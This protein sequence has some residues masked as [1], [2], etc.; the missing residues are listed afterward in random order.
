MLTLVATLIAEL[1]FSHQ[2]AYDK[3][4][5]RRGVLTATVCFPTGETGETESGGETFK[6]V[7]VSGVH[8]GPPVSVLT[9]FKW[10][11]D[12][13]FALMD[14]F[15]CQTSELATEIDSKNCLLCGDFNAVVNGKDYKTILSQLKGLNHLTKHFEKKPKCT[16][17]PVGEI[18]LTRGLRKSKVREFRATR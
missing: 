11:P 6:D 12:W 9:F 15:H 2:L 14:K 17:N 5:V 7:K 18:L 13:F 4:L 1:A 3:Y 16:A 10:L 8:I